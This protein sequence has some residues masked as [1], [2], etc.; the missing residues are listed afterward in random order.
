MVLVI[1][2]TFPGFIV[3]ARPIGLLR[4]LDGKKRDDKILAV[5]TLGMQSVMNSRICQNIS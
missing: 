3:T 1:N 2:P 4:M 5:P